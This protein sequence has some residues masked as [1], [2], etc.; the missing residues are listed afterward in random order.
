MTIMQDLRKRCWGRGYLKIQAQ[1]TSNS[2]LSKNVL[3]VSSLKFR[4]RFIWIKQF[5]GFPN[6]HKRVKIQYNTM[7]EKTKEDG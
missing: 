2:P 1:L 7:K 3:Q 6:Q 4:M 5:I